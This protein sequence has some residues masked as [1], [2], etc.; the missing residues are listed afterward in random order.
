MDEQVYM[1]LRN[2]KQNVND[3]VEEY[4]EWILNLPNSFQYLTDNHLLTTFLKVGLLL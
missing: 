2:V 3:Q 1:S 4:Y